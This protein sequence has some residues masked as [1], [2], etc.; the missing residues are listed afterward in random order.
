[1]SFRFDAYLVS[2]ESKWALPYYVIHVSFRKYVFSLSL[3]LYVSLSLSL[4]FS[5]VV[6]PF[7]SFVLFLSFSIFLSFSPFVNL[8]PPLSLF[9]SE[10]ISFCK[11]EI[12][13]FGTHLKDDFGRT[14]DQIISDGFDIKY[15]IENL[16]NGDKAIDIVKSYANT[17]AVFGD[18]WHEHRKRFDIVICLGDRF[19]MAAAVNAGIPFNIN[20]AP[21]T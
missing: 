20:F 18:F 11:L 2:P 6:Y 21:M 16:I 19:E 15:S 10:F 7:L 5:L 1:M 14:Q 12:I 3:S 4:S 9:L 13:A 8:S 17:V